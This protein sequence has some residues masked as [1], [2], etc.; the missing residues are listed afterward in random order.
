[1]HIGKVRNSLKI[2]LVLLLG[3][4]LSG[5]GGTTSPISQTPKSWLGDWN[6]QKSSE[7]KSAF[8]GFKKYEDSFEGET[9]L[10]LPDNELSPVGDG[11]PFFRWSIYSGIEST[12]NE[13]VP[14]VA[15]AYL[16]EDWQFYDTLKIK[17]GEDVR[18]F[19][20]LGDPYREADGG[21]VNEILTF[22]L[23]KEEAEFLSQ[24]FTLGNPEIRLGGSAAIITDVQLSKIELDNLKKVLLAYKYIVNE[25]IKP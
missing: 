4:S 2:F 14:L 13:F 18:E 10:D 1:M 16:G 21:Y 8:N 11:K 15:V 17:F 20:M 5:C 12:Q 9:Y 19:T 25:G 22:T 3:I 7:A 24:V 23:T 6:A